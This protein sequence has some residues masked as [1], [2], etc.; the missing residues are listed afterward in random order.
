MTLKFKPYFALLQLSSRV[1]D[2]CSVTN[3][4]HDNFAAFRG[5]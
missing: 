4:I 2:Y 3:D 5:L 1:N